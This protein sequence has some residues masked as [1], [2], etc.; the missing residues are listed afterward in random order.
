VGAASVGAEV[1]AGSPGVQA[2]SRPHVRINSSAI[3]HFF[4]L[5]VILSG[6][7][8]GLPR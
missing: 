7:V 6:F 8:S 3:I 1:S 5:V 4:M 2:I